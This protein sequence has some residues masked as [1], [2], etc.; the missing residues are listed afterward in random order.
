MSPGF[1]PPVATWYSSGWNVLYRFLSMIV[2]SAPALL[3]PLTAD[4]PANP[5]PTIT[6]CVMLPFLSACRLARVLAL[7]PA[8]PAPPFAEPALLGP[9]P[10]DPGWSAGRAPGRPAG[11]AATGATCAG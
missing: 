1:S 3:R 2:T 7:A 5:A 6:T 9:V 10:L 8:F 4:R 11:C